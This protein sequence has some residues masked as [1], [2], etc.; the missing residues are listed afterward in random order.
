MANKF[1]LFGPNERH[2]GSNCIVGDMMVVNGRI[3][4]ATT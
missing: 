2:T 4:E 1:L 3:A